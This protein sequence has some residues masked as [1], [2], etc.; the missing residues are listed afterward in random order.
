[1]ALEWIR[2]A[3][4]T[5]FPMCNSFNSTKGARTKAV[6]VREGGGRKHVPVVGVSNGALLSCST[7][8]GVGSHCW[9]TT[10]GEYYQGSWLF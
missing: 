8:K 5:V 9:A 10:N 3:S 1:M 2:T 6:K 7:S 4:F